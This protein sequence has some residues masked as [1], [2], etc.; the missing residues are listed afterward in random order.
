[1]NWSAPGAARNFILLTTAAF[2]LPLTATLLAINGYWLWLVALVGAIGVLWLFSLQPVTHLLL[3]FAFLPFQSL[4]NDLF[5]GSIPMIA[6][7]KDALMVIVLLAFLGRQMIQRRGW[8]L[9]TVITLLLALVVISTMC[10]LASPYLMRGILA[11]RF[12]T[13]YPLIILLVANTI[14]SREDF[15]K[16]LRVV[17][18]VGVITVIYGIVQYL[19]QF[20]VPYRISGGDVKLRMGRFNEMGAVSTFASRPTFGGYLSPLF[21]LFMQNSLWQHSIF[22]SWMR[23]PILAAIG[24]AA[25][26]TFSRTSWLALIVGVTVALYFRNK[27]QAV[28]AAAGLVLCGVLFSIA[29]IVSTSESFAEA[30]TDN[31]SF[32]IRLSYWPMVASHV[33]VNPFGIGLG[34]VGGPHLFEDEARADIYGNLRYDQN[35]SF[36]P[37]ADLSSGTLAVT[38]NTFLKLFVQGGFPLLIIFLCFVG[39]VLRLAH[40]LL[41]SSEGRQNDSPNDDWTRGLAIWGMASFVSLL[42][43][44]MFVDFLESAPAISLFW[45]AVGGLC[46]AR[47]LSTY[48]DK[49]V[50]QQSAIETCNN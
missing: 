37:N 23:W 4:L 46:C 43:I 40:S 39:A 28:L 33:L 16:L 35:T 42:T 5:A 45:L 38:D 48:P 44:F 50:T 11:L 9:D 41:K 21:L 12:L 6:I 22:K 17:A 20:D 13:L 8:Y 47:K 1:M 32:F 29:Q 19:T 27:A 10:A 26:L 3:V 30:A 25:L 24:L 15:N 18:I 49:L 36:D 34:T 2:L 14:E 31:Q 7:A